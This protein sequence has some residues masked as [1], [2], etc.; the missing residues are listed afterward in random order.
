MQHFT[1]STTVPF[2]K[3]IVLFLREFIYHDWDKNYNIWDKLMKVLENG[4][5]LMV[6]IIKILSKNI[7]KVKNLKKIL[8][9]NPDPENVSFENS[10]I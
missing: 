5:F 3:S 10:C 4:L 6:M 9:E 7:L 8:N 2:F 1:L